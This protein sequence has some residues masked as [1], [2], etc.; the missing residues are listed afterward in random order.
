MTHTFVLLEL[1]QEAYDE[2][3]SKLKNA[4]YDHAFEDHG[5]IDMHGLAVHAKRSKPSDPTNA[6]DSAMTVVS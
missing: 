3:A 4:G 6:Y 1:S 2:I 5:V